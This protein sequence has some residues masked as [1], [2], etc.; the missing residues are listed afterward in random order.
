MTRNVIIVDNA[1]ATQQ[2]LTRG[3]DR[4]AAAVADR[5]ACH[6]DAA[7]PSGTTAIDLV[8]HDLGETIRGT[9]G[10]RQPF[11]REHLH[12]VIGPLLR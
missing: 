6:H 4:D 5:I 2:D 7:Q 8:L 1:V 11:E 3:L 10:S 9:A 12:E